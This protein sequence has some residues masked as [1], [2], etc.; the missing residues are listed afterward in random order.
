M[1]EACGALSCK[2]FQRFLIMIIPT[3]NSSPTNAKVLP[4][5]KVFSLFVVSDAWEGEYL[6]DANVVGQTLAFLLI[7]VSCANSNWMDRMWIICAVWSCFFSL[8]VGRMGW[9]GSPGQGVL[10]SF[11][12]TILF[13][14]DGRRP[15]FFGIAVCLGALEKRNR[16]IFEYYLEAGVKEF[17][18]RTRFS[19]GWNWA[20]KTYSLSSILLEQ[21]YCRSLG[22]LFFDWAVCVNLGYC[23]FWVNKST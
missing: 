21:Q 14:T 12:K 11:V 20:F 1:L 4:N 17:W 7:G 5:V 8:A 15:K 19:L 6:Q 23:C 13:L 3:P 22:F 9:Y 16:R 18:D 10:W 2:S